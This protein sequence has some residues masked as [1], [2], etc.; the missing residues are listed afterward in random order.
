MVW[1]GWGEGDRKKVKKEKRYDTAGS[2]VIPHRG[3]KAACAHLTAGFEMGPGAR[4]SSVVVSV[5]LLFHFL[6]L[7]PPGYHWGRPPLCI[8]IARPIQ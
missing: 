6:N 7:F 8:L 3:T 5:S 2:L 4:A 1:E